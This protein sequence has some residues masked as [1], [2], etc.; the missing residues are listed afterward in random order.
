MLITI[1]MTPVGKGRPRVVNRNGKS[2]TYTPVE[3]AD[4][5]AFIQIAVKQAAGDF[6]IMP[7]VPIYIEATFYRNRP[8]GDKNR[9]LPHTKPDIDNTAKL[10]TDALEGILY[11]N[12]AQIT[13]CVLR[14]R[15]GRPRIEFRIEEDEGN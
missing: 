3:T 10:L 1:H 15:F 11:K 9:S 2:V 12:D 13:T 14:K 4:A 6:C 8:K 5:E 7:G